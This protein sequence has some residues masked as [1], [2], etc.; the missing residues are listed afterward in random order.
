MKKVPE[1]LNLLLC[2]TQWKCIFAFRLTS[3]CFRGVFVIEKH[4]FAL[5]NLLP[6]Q[7]KLVLLTEKER[8]G[9][10]GKI[11]TIDKPLLC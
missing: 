1:P 5:W 3:E 6:S 7:W 9:A 2:R 11:K 10:H 4:Y 8:T